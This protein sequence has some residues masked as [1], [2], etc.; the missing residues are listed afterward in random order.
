MNEQTKTKEQMNLTINEMKLQMKKNEG[1]SKILI[2]KVDELY[3][4]N[5]II[6]WQ[7]AC[8]EENIHDGQV[9]LFKGDEWLLDGYDSY[10]TMSFM[11]HKKVD[12]KFQD[13][14][15]ELQMTS[16]S[17]LLEHGKLLKDVEKIDEK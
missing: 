7:I 1:E 5:F 17:K 13:E 12:G 8:I 14:V 10:F 16:I 3:T 2:A 15:K 4:E 9:W 11:A 6:E